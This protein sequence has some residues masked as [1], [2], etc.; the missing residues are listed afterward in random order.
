MRRKAALRRARST[1]GSSSL[2]A[3]AAWAAV[4]DSDIHVSMSQREYYRADGVRIQHDPYHEGMADKYGKPGET[5]QEGFDPYAG[6]E[7]RDRMLSFMFSYV[8]FYWI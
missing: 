5:D 3:G 4:Q 1:P 8:V 2:I 6:I 7:P